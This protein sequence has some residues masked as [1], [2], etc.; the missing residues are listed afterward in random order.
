M[1]LA[2]R[3]VLDTST[4]VSVAL[5]PESV[6]RQAFQRILARCEICSSVDTLDEL[7]EV[8]SRSKFERYLERAERT[9]FAGLYRRHAVLHQ[10]VHAVSDCRDPKDNKFL[11]LA[12][13][14]TADVIVASDKD[15]L[16][17]NPYRGI[18]VLTPAAFLDDQRF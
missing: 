4:L 8:L 17:L 14:C 6:P 10:V 15:L 2:K 5:R 18:P 16:V 3:V 11:A 12:L 1:A 13:A 9:A 7:A